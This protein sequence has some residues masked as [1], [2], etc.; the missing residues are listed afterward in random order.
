[1]MKEPAVRGLESA[2]GHEA[3]SVRERRRGSVLIRD[4]WLDERYRPET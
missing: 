2:Y 1:M 4:S 3:C